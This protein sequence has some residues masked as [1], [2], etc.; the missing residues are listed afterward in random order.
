MPGLCLRL[1]A[2]LMNCLRDCRA[3]SAVEFALLLPV[4]VT[5]YLGSVEVSRGIAAKR[6]VTLIAHALADLTAQ[7]NTIHDQD[8]SNVLAAGSAIIAPF[9]ATPL[10]E[11]VSELT[12]DSNGNATVTWSG[13]LN[14]TALAVGS[15]VSVPSGLAVPNTY[16]IMAQ[17]NY[18]YDPTFGYVLTKTITLSDQIYMAPRQSGPITRVSP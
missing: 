18:T 8:L 14:G 4:M 5:L 17:V 13:T 3:V 1:T 15:T 6:N 2:R 12:L 11:T 7:Y 10:Q 16:L 9:P